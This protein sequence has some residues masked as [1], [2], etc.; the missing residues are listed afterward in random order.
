MG[1]RHSCPAAP[2]TTRRQPDGDTRRSPIN[3]REHVSF[4]RYA[5]CRRLGF[6]GC[7]TPR[8]ARGRLEPADD[9]RRSRDLGSN[10]T[11]LATNCL[12]IGTPTWFHR[13]V[14]GRRHG[15]YAE[16]RR[17]TAVSARSAVSSDLQRRSRTIRG[18]REPAPRRTTPATH[19]LPPAQGGLPPYNFEDYQQEPRPTARARHH[20]RAMPINAAVTTTSADRH[21][22]R[23]PAT[24][25]AA[26]VL[27]GVPRSDAA[28][29][30]G[31]ARGRHLHPFGTT[32]RAMRTRRT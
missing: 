21:A 22:G 7:M 27:R 25:G 5:E 2:R 18:R 16:A 31:P 19:E 30:R 23:Q 14:D 3:E 26:G 8:P 4:G 1:G 13:R 28:G 29:A 11:A 32:R 9:P 24:A 17:T 15:S 10:G 12:S 20:Q 6:V